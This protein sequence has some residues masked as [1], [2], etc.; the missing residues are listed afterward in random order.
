MFLRKRKAGLSQRRQN[1]NISFRLR[2]QKQKH[3]E[4]VKENN[5]INKSESENEKEI[6]ANEEEQIVNSDTLSILSTEN[7]NSNSNLDS[8]TQNLIPNDNWQIDI[9]N[10]LSDDEMEYNDSNFVNEENEYEDQTVD[11]ETKQYDNIMYNLGDFITYYDRNSNTSINYG[12]IIGFVICDKTKCFLIK[13]ER[14]LDFNSLPN[15]LKSR[16]RKNQINN[17]QK[18]WMTDE[19]EMIELNWIE[20]KINVWLMDTK[21]PDNYDYCINEIVYKSNN[22]WNTRSVDLRHKHPIEYTPIRKISDELPI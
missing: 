1:Q 22:K 7:L 11:S 17:T 4:Q 19:N 3:V 10:L 14:I 16:Q 21:K 2:K 15:L 5:N 18:L 8:L 13:A 9:S 6:S 12:R 20:S